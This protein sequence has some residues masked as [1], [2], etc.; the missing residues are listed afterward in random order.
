MNRFY[1]TLASIL[2]AS[3][4]LTAC[5]S[6]KE[7]DDSSFV[8][9]PADQ[10]FNEGLALLNSGKYSR[11]AKRF[12]DL[13]EQHPYSEYTRR[14]AVLTTYAYYTNGKYDD[15]IS[16]GE[17]YI[18]LHPGSEEAPYVQYLVAQSYFRGMPD[19]T[20]DQEQTKKA[21]RKLNE[22]IERYPDSEYVDD[23]RDKILVVNDQL[24]GKEMTIGRYY[25]ERR[26]FIAA[27]ERFKTVVTEYQTTRHVEEALYRLTESYL[28]LGIVNEAQTA[29]AILGHNFPDS[30]WYK[31]AY[32]L[33]QEG[34][35]EPSENRGSWLSRAFERF[36]R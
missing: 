30:P 3:T 10:I 17:R 34:G 21:L 20:R 16:T 14:A 12:E 8:E 32:S 29:A 25:L 26:Q 24:A 19:V 1:R 22:L 28:A 4:L 15:A 11:A 35:L 36:V 27:I 18:T 31:D 13:E 2:L 5:S 6:D 9:E 23:A 33:L 7:I